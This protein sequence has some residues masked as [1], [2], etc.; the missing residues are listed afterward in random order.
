MDPLQSIVAALRL[1]AH[2]IGQDKSQLASQLLGRLLGEDDPDVR[3]LL[4]TANERRLGPWLRPLISSL[5]PPGGPL[6]RILA[7]HAGRVWAVAVDGA[8]QLAVS[9][10]D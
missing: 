6:L 4:G 3:R 7:G 10:S 5:T 1:S 8:G 2:V 9:G